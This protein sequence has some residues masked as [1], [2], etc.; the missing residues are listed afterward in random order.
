MLKPTVHHMV[1]R[2]MAGMAR[3][4]SVSQEMRFDAEVAK[5]SGQDTPLRIQQK[6][7]NQGDYRHREDI[8]RKKERAEEAQI[9]GRPVQ[10]H[11]QEQSQPHDQRREIRTNLKVLSES[12]RRL[13]R[14]NAL[15]PLDG[16]PKTGQR[17]GRIAQSA[18]RL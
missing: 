15:L 11:G 4:G 6:S 10:K 8:G 3:L 18:I 1:V 13:H 16:Y 2:I 14:P 5:K 12:A 17:R 9:A 7:P